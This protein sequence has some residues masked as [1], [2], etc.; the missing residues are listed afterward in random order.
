MGVGSLA[1][2]VPS[3]GAA[4]LASRFHPPRRF[5]AVRFDT[6]VPNPQH[7]SQTTALA[8]MSALAAEVAAAAPP[9]RRRWARG[10]PEADRTAAG[11]YLDGGYGVGKTHLLA[12]TWHAA[13]GPK[14][15][16]TFAELAAVIGFLGME[17][18]V[19][20]FSGYR[21][22]CIDEFELDDVAN[23]LMTVTF[24]RSIMPAGV[25]VAATSNSLPERLG[26]GRF[27]AE[28][29]KREIEAIA[30]WF[31]VVRID[32]PDYRATAPLA[33]VHPDV[34]AVASLSAGTVTDDPFAV[35]LSH[36]RRVHPVQYGA[37][38][39]DVDTVIVRDLAPIHDQ[40]SALNWVAFVDELYDTAVAFGATGCEV[41]AIFDPSYRHGG[42][43][44]KYGRCESRLA[45]M[46][47]G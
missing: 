1:D 45:A 34:S 35:V 5:D 8:E 6:F 31:E 15:Y 44:K 40:G 7:D 28:D 20:A 26:E 18:A 41:G 9:T 39:D 46:L 14:A 32:G 29:F 37:M 42:Y 4:E 3:L 10:K 30:S 24:L 19:H 23:T 11:R 21:L 47:Q 43:R 17:A 22:L 38:L 16:L 33:V 13:P 25:R 12:A 27:S 36:L 2:R